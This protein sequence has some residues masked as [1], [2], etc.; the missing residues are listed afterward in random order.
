MLESSRA[1]AGVLPEEAEA[2]E[3]Q[4]ISLA[5]DLTQQPRLCACFC[6][7]CCKSVGEG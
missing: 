3:S 4:H 7:V 6:S 1:D 5:W 2:V